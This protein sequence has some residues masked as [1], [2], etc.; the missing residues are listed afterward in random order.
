[1]L[2][3]SIATGQKAE[4]FSITMIRPSLSGLTKRTSFASS[5]CSLV[6]IS[7]PYSRAYQR[8]PPILRQ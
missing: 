2:A 3:V 4:A 5:L 6:L 8:L 7:E 1:M